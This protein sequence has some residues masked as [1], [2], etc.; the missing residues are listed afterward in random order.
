MLS[1]AQRKKTAESTM[2]L[3]AEPGR[4]AA[5]LACLQESSLPTR[6]RHQK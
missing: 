4:L 2:L 6:R 5:S 3:L 1:T